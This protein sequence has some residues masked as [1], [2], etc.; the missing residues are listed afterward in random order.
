[1]RNVD[2]LSRGK[3]CTRNTSMIGKTYFVD[4]CAHSDTREEFASTLVMQ[5]EGRSL[6]SQ[7]TGRLP[8]HSL[9][10]RVKVEL[11]R[12]VSDDVEDRQFLSPRLLH[13]LHLR[14][15]LKCRYRLGRD[16]L[17]QDL[18]APCKRTVELVKR[19]R[20]ADN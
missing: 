11:R 18:I 7:D 5:K 13:P 8:H 14:R 12:D 2:R 9:Q 4:F 6:G 20:H 10:N 16:A 17:R 19:L 1:M 15:A 3:H